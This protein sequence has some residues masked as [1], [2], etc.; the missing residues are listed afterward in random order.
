[1]GVLRNSFQP[2]STLMK[3]QAGGSLASHAELDPSLPVQHRKRAVFKPIEGESTSKRFSNPNKPMII[4]DSKPLE[5][6]L[7][8]LSFKSKIRQKKGM[9]VKLVL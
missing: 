1:M 7:E 8:E 4:Y 2:R 6:T 9:G 5:K 3:R